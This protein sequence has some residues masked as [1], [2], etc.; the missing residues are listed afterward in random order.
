ME[1]EE[2]ELTGRIVKVLNVDEDTQKVHARQQ[3]GLTT[4]FTIL[5]GNLPFRGDVL[6]LGADRWELAP[7]DTWLWAN[8]VATVRAKVGDE[9]ILVDDGIHI[10]PVINYGNVD[11]EIHNTVE[12]NDID[13]IIRVVADVPIRSREYGIS[14]EDILKEY[15]VDTSEGGPT[16]ADFGGYPDVVERAKELIATQLDH[17]ET[18]EVIGA[19]PVKGILFT[20]PPGTGKTHLARI[21]AHASKADFYLVSGPSIVSK[22]VGD[23]EDTLRKIFDAAA[24]S[25][26]G[27]AIV[28]FDE[29]D[30][31]AERRTGESHEAS[32]RLVAQLLTLLDGFSSEGG[33][34]VV[35]AATNRA[36]SLDPALMR[37]GRF[38]W[39]I[40]FTMPTVADRLEIL[41]V[42][43]RKLQTAEWLPLIDI[44][45]LTEGWSAAELNALWA[46]AA[47][48]A[49]KDSRDFIAAE[50]LALALER[51]AARPRREADR[52]SL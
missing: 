7:P 35:V 34:V 36:E 4:A 45:A 50:D 22:W 9:E 10:K 41:E 21:I 30:S 31:I 3:D 27:R 14:R 33:G 18:L 12:Y 43:A 23:T 39:E 28:F 29:I 44:A 40:E 11:V 49:A 25:E 2:A 16:F 5:N 38:D 48:L 19:R 17:R 20:G 52:G 6:L 8:S 51:V 46:E 15:R 47:I 32:K 13:G 24:A 26:C 42:H 1:R 37:P